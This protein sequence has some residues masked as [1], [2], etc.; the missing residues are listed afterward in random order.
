[1]CSS[2]QCSHHAVPELSDMAPPMMQAE[3]SVSRSTEE[4][5]KS[6]SAATRQLFQRLQA[7]PPPS[8]HAFDAVSGLPCLSSWHDFDVTWQLFQR[9][10]APPPPSQHAFDAVRQSCKRLTCAS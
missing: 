7:L 2:V 10:Q 1:M 9:L 8:Q 6:A 5:G 3:P 4:L